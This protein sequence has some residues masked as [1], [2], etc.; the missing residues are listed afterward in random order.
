MNVWTHKHFPHIPVILV[1]GYGNLMLF[2]PHNL[3]HLVCYSFTHQ[4]S[5][6]IICIKKPQKE[7][8]RKQNIFYPFYYKD[9]LIFII[10]HVSIWCD[11]MSTIHIDIILPF[12][13]VHAHIDGLF[14]DMKKEIWFLFAC[15]ILSINNL[16]GFVR[17]AT[18]L[19]IWIR[20]L[21]E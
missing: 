14:G 20:L 13:I 18:I 8:C 10:R 19:G 21:H 5:N 9:K 11:S 16:F 17:T 1:F 12:R 15:V 4:F 6:N 7:I 2:L 3:N